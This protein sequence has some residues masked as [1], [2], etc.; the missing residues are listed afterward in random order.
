M[1]GY[2][3][4]LV[5]LLLLLFQKAIADYLNLPSP[6]LVV[7]LAIGVAFY[8]PLGSPRGYIQGAYGF[9]SSRHQSRSGGTG[10]TRRISPAASSWASVS[11]RDRGQR[12]RCCRG[13]SCCCDRNSRPRF[14]P[15]SHLPDAFREALQAIVFFAGQVLINN[16][17][18]VLV[19]HFFPSTAA[20]LYAAVALVGRVMFAFSS[21]V[22][23]T[24]FPLMAGTRK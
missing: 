22:V 19:K 18:I 6:I 16:C 15:S 20:G 10:S 23:N 8:V 2:A 12:R 7:L 3:A 9:R 4:S 17:D 11:R 24:M 5:A 1:R 14:Q 21:A 13:L